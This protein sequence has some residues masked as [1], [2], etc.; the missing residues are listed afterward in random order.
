[1][2]HRLVSYDKAID[3]SLHDFLDNTIRLSEF[4]GKKVLL[5]FFRVAT[6]SFCNLRVRELITRHADFEKQDIHVIAVF[7]SAAAEIKEYAGKQLPPFPVIPDPNLDLYKKYHIE[8]SHT[9]LLR[10]MLKP[11]QLLKVIRSGF[12]NMKSVS[13]KPLLPAEFLIDTN[14]FIYRSYYGQ[15]YGDHLP[16]ED[17]LTWRQP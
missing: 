1:M 12:F 4:R 10:I 2:N 11:L 6:C 7:A 14:Q 17:I 9:G 8:Q 15:D 16:I 13:K 5:A 3:F